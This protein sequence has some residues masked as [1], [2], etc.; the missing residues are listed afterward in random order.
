MDNTNINFAYLQGQFDANFEH[1]SGLINYGFFPFTSP[2]FTFEKIAKVAMYA[3]KKA[4]GKEKKS[5]RALAKKSHEMA[6]KIYKLQR[7]QLELQM[8]VF[9]GSEGRLFGSAHD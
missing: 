3:S 1:Y 4:D 7:A 8:R 6:K 5:L 2:K 9:E